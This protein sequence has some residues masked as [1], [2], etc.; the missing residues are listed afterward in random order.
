MGSSI[1][2]CRRA[3][4]TDVLRSVVSKRKKYDAVVL[5]ALNGFLE[6]WNIGRALQPGSSLFAE[7]IDGVAQR[8]MASSKGR[9]V[10]VRSRHVTFSNELREAMGRVRQG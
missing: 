6:M 3:V 9:Q 5:F 7:Y 8:A 1:A 2:S 4:S 10:S